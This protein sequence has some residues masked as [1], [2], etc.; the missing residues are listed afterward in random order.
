M[1]FRPR[2]GYHLCPWSP[3]VLWVYGKRQK[4]WNM[5]ASLSG[6][7]ELLILTLHA[8]PATFW[9][10]G[11]RRCW[12]SLSEGTVPAGPTFLICSYSIRHLKYTS[13]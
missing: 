9:E 3:R 10:H 8:P 4:V 6:A 5:E 12:A 7:A 11:S 13:K 2:S 1:Y